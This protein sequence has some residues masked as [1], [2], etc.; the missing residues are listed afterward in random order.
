MY[1]EC[2]YPSQVCRKMGIG[3]YKNRNMSAVSTAS[4]S[5]IS[6]SGPSSRASLCSSNPATLEHRGYPPY[7]V[8]CLSPYEFTAS[9]G[10]P[11]HCKDSRHSKHQLETRNSKVQSS[12]SLIWTETSEEHSQNS[13]HLERFHT[14][15][16][17]WAASSALETFL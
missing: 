5:Q 16:F 17:S 13:L 4:A 3:H 2:P 10:T 12:C 8:H 11:K 6:E 9:S 14:Y 15:A 7:L 1:K